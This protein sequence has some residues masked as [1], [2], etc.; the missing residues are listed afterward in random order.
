MAILERITSQFGDN[1]DY[2]KDAEENECIMRGYLRD[3]PHVPITVDG[4]PGNDTLQ[5]N[6]DFYKVQTAF[7]RRSLF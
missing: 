4:C 1:N 2:K 5:V 3:E 7:Q 6:H